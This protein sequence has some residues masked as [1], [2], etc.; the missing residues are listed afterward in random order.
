MADSHEVAVGRRVGKV[1]LCDWR[2]LGCDQQAV[3]GRR[4]RP[5][6]NDTAYVYPQLLAF[7]Y[8]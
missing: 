8:L 2:A 6:L 4:E 5:N 3:A 7:G 1:C